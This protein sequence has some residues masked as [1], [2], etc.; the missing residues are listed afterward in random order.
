MS[1]H[2]TVSVT[3]QPADFRQTLSRFASGV[4]VVTARTAGGRPVGVTASAFT[5]VSLHP[6][7]VLVCLGKATVD[8]PAF[9]EGDHFAVNILDERQ[10][11]LSAAFA[12]RGGDKFAE[13]AHE[14][15]KT[16]C[17]I[18]AGCIANL[19]CAR[20]EV[21]DGGDHV[22]ILGR[23]EGLCCVEGARPLL[24]FRGGYH[25]LGGAA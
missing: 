24:H 7:L 8:L 2:K 18:L 15:W 22:I 16:G 5:S 11:D 6:P 21:H 17:P 14:T 25:R 1:E 10:K 23:V 20:T 9:A 13:V 3:V 12:R 19:E 4:T